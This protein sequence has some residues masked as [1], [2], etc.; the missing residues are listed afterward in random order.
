MANASRE[1]NN[2]T[3][4]QLY[5]NTLVR[6]PVQ[7]LRI[8]SSILVARLLTPDDYGIMGIGM[9][10]IGYAN[11][12][13]T[14]GFGDALVQR[15]IDDRRIINSVFTV[16]LTI[17]MLLSSLFFMGSGAIADFFNTPE[18]ENVVKVL[19]SFFIV[20][21]F[22]STP[23]AIL[24]RDMAFKAI[25][26]IDVLKGVMIAGIT[27]TLAILGFEYWSLVFGQ[28]ITFA[29]VSL[30]LCLRAKWVP[31][32]RFNHRLMKSIYDFGVWSF[33]KSQ[34][35][36]FSKDADKFIVGRWLGTQALGLYD[37]AMSLAVMP[38]NQVTVNIN[39]VLF[40]SFSKNQEK[41]N[42][43]RQQMKKSLTLIA[44]INFPLFAGLGVIA[45]Y[46]VNGLL[47]EKWAPMIPAFQI[48]LAGCMFKSFS[49]LVT[50]FNVGV[51]KYRQH[52]IR[53]FFALLGFVGACFALLSFGINGIAAAFLFYS[54]L[55]IVLTGAITCGQLSISWFDL[56][57]PVI[58]PL[59]GAL[60]MTGAV[61]TLALLA[62]PKHTALNLALLCLAGALAYGAYLVIDRSWQTRELKK[63]IWKD[64]RKIPFAGK[65]L[66][67]YS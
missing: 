35:A 47:G 38:L 21:A 23:H 45:P 54:I 43:L 1:N 62:L 28:L 16:D 60:V 40:S 3:R 67:G 7:A 63:T 18:A 19:S 17:S 42:E 34:L 8:I 37:K 5:W 32:P 66:K 22:Q 31:A 25:A 33:L 56:L 29:V 48:I 4:K 11:L 44:G 55:Y 51:G 10:L 53:S 9:M 59:A 64:I 39:A 26:I 57:L 12:F 52:T 6:I 27:L 36:F 41:K 65:L 58:P 50:V 2:G 46:F 13:T 14:F 24:R 61:H 15:N 49:G 20:T 30:A